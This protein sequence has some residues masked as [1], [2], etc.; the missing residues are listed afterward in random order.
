MEVSIE[1]PCASAETLLAKHNSMS[2][3]ANQ[4]TVFAYAI[5]IV[6]G[7]MCNY[8]FKNRLILYFI[9]Q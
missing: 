7:N 1:L 6:D 4:S 8:Q 3:P 9:F 2:A 5:M